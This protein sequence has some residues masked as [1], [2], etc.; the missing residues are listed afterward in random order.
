VACDVSSILEE[1]VNLAFGTANGEM[2]WGWLGNQV[3]LY[4]SKISQGTGRTNRISIEGLDNKPCHICGT[5]KIGIRIWTVDSGFSTIA[6]PE[7]SYLSGG[8]TDM[9]QKLSP[10][11][12]SAEAAL[13]EWKSTSTEKHTGG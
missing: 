9:A 4:F 11:V 6:D 10:S 3:S 8:G 2:W 7:G 1:V 12:A 13:I 5:M